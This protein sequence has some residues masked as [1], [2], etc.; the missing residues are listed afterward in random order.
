MNKNDYIIIPYGKV[1]VIYNLFIFNGQY[2]TA[3]LMVVM[4]KM[5]MILTGIIKSVI[6]YNT[7]ITVC[8]CTADRMY[9]Y[10]Y[11]IQKNNIYDKI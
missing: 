1:A 7:A 8:A 11:K 6:K 3:T 5:I 9:D 2:I 4:I 10:I